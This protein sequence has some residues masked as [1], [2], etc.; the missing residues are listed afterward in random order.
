MK[1][2]AVISVTALMLILPLSDSGAFPLE[3]SL[4][5]SVGL[6]YYSM[7]K[8]NRHINARRQKI[9]ANLDQITNG[10]NIA[11]EGRIWVL[12]RA[13]LTMGYEHFY[14]EAQV[15]AETY[16]VAYRAP[17]GLYSLGVAVS[18]LKLTS[19]DINAG[20]N[21]IFGLSDYQTNEYTG[22][23]IQNF[24]AADN[25]LEIFTEITTNFLKPVEVGFQLGYR[26]LEFKPFVNKFRDEIYFNQEE[27]QKTVLD[28]SGTYFYLTTGI[29]I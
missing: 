12:G 10:I 26:R 1:R 19:V 7:E 24:K 23:L 9:G 29:R 11:A 13:A 18:A 15:D 3:L 17:V 5:G 27:N 20:I 6:G 28:Y 16:S 4:R 25:G 21:R 8:L 2:L 22:G 14:A